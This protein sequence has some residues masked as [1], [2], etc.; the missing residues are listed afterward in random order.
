MKQS[1]PHLFQAL[2]R[3]ILLR[4]FY[5]LCAVFPEF[6]TYIRQHGLFEKTDRLI[7]A[8]SGGVDSVVLAHLLKQGGFVFSLA[9]CNFRLRG[10]DSDEDERWCRQLAAELGV[11]ITVKV[12]DTEAYCREHRLN[13]QLA[14]RKLRYEWFKELLQQEQAR[15]LLTAHH[16]S[17]LTETVLI[18]LLRGTGIR[19]LRGIARKQDP[20]VRPLLAFTRTQIEEYAQQQNIRFRLDKSNLE[21]K[22]ERNYIRNQVIPLLKRLNP[23]LEETFTRNTGHF[24]EE[25]AIVEAYLSRRAT[26]L[27][28]S[29]QGCLVL[30]KDALLQEPYPASLLN[31]LLSDYGFNETQ[32]GNIY[33]HLQQNALPGKELL[34]PTHR[35]SIDRHELLIRPLAE[36]AQEGNI[37]I[38]SLEELETQDR[39][40]LQVPEK[41]E[42]PGKEE[43]IVQRDRLVFPLT[44]RGRK[45]GDKFIPFGMKGFKLLSDLFREEKLN[46]FE[47]EACLILQNG[48]GEIIWVIGYRS[49]ERYRV[50]PADGPLVK[51]K[52]LG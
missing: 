39:F 13:V 10:A 4:P 52:F 29:R 33:R 1:G 51:L 46:T 37:L 16:A 32:Q 44:L 8:L 2:P 19:G 12:F 41:F 25:A 9:H 34:S 49:D 38:R 50:G 28:G 23:G 11:A 36:E 40:V 20:L 31:Y 27:T 5:Y 3:C 48:N 6:E 43:L 22:Y 35:L 42:I 24:R 17:D 45:T 30:G 18:N 26:E 47:K 15:Y 7:L 21:D 14:A